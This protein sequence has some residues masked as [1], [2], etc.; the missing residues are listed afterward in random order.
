M[1]CVLPYYVSMKVLL[2]VRNLQRPLS[3]ARGDTIHHLHRRFSLASLEYLESCK[4]QC[5]FYGKM[6]GFLKNQSSEGLFPF[7]PKG[8]SNYA[9]T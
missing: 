6:H 1:V 4:G 7:P 8:P 3:P 2:L 5:I 9:Y